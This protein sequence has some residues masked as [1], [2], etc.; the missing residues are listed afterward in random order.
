MNELAIIKQEIDWLNIIKL[1][2]NKKEWGKT[3]T[4]YISE[5]VSVT[6]TMKI[7]DFERNLA[8]F[9]IQIKY[10]KD[11]YFDSY[12]N[13]NMANYYLN[14]YSINDFKLIILKLIRRTIN[15]IIE[16]RTLLKAEEIFK[17]LYMSLENINKELILSSKYNKEYNYSEKI[18]NQNIRFDLQQSIRKNIQKDININYDKKINIYC[19]ENR[20][21]IKGMDKI[22]KNINKELNK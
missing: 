3:Y 12:Y 16:K 5:N 14:N 2:F 8:E 18:N 4:L 20:N 17:H 22:L 21:V 15:D 11:K 19:K 6:A 9:K 1:V 7:F 13:Y 10:K